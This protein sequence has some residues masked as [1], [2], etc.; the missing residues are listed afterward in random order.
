MQWRCR[1]T[2]PAAGET[3]NH[4]DDDPH[5][6]HTHQQSL[7][8]HV[9]EPPSL[10]EAKLGM[11][12]DGAG[13]PGQKGGGQKVNL[14]GND[15]ISTAQLS[16]ITN[17]G[18][19]KQHMRQHL[20]QHALCPSGVNAVQAQS[21]G[22]AVLVDGHAHTVDQDERAVGQLGVRL[23]EVSRS[24]ATERLQAEDTSTGKGHSSITGTPVKT[25]QLPAAQVGDGGQVVENKRQRGHV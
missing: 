3:I 20:S 10:L 6:G 14:P 25:L 17:S 4:G 12:A 13:A 5:I 22:T 24:T 18:Q 23:Q 15:V 9:A 19:N 16:I 21:H 11:R 7:E 8:H 2:P 1:I